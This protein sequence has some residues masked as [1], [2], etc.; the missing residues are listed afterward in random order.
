MT[1]PNQPCYPTPELATLGASLRQRVASEQLAGLLSNPECADAPGDML[2]RHAVQMTDGL[3][4]A[5]DGLQI[6]MLPPLDTLGWEE[7]ERVGVPIL[8]DQ[9]GE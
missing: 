3:L 8:A 2:I 1:H 5:L 4:M 6:P 9:D 7:E